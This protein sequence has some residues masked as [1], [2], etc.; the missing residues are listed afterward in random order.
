MKRVVCF[1]LVSL[2]VLSLSATE[3]LSSIME[4][5]K[6]NSS[7][8]ESYRLAL[9]NTT[10]TQQITDAEEKVSVEVDSG[11]F[12][13]TWENMSSPS[14]QVNGTSV[15]VTI[16]HKEDGDTVIEGSVSYNKTSATDILT[17]SLSFS[18]TF[19]YGYN[20]D[21]RKK[22]LNAQ[23]NLAT[24]N[25]AYQTNL[26][27][28]ENSLY[29]EISSL[30]TSEK[31]IL[32]TTH[33]IETAQKEIDDAIAL[34][35]LDKTSLAYQA[36]VNALTVKRHTLAAYEKQKEVLSQQYALVVGSSWEGVSDIPVP[37]LSFVPNP[38]GNTTVLLKKYTLDLAE[39]ELKIYKA[40]LTDSTLAIG[41]SVTESSTFS[42]GTNTFTGNASA[43]YTG[44]NYSVQ[45]G[46]SYSQ[47]NNGLSGTPSIYVGAS[48]NNNTTSDTEILMLRKMENAVILARI[49]YANALNTYLTS[50]AE[51]QKKISDWEISYAE[52][53]ATLAYDTQLLEQQNI[54]FSSGLVS[55]NTLSDSQ[56]TLESD[57]YALNSCLLNGLVIANSIKMLEL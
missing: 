13:T 40:S 15:T 55:K 30:I 10:L 42:T 50:G 52:A 22:I 14:Y 23:A 4:K 29:S 9:E 36:K 34:R 28:F 7:Q 41:G 31:N 56:T 21:E 45:G 20:G 43:T 26:L 11:T 38:N 37:T 1:I 16:P 18:H 27:T 48:W 49:E 8:P 39:E 25:N 46:V 19:E 5:A 33:A 51:M 12:S 54:L 2:S 3:T 17:P 6:G 57:G 35:T 53:Q 44:S 47:S 24:A 32:V